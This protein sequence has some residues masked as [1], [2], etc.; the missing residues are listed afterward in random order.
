MLTID[1]QVHTYERNHPGRPWVGVLH[2]PAHVTGDEM[3]AAMDLGY[4]VDGAMLVSP[5][6]IVS[7]RCQAT[8][9][10]S[11]RRIPAGSD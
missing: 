3:V 5:F 6:A 1:C 8:R 2:G 7:L 11:T 9:L 10:K 4:D